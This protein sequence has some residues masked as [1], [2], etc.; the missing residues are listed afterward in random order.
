MSV[1]PIVDIEELT[2]RFLGPN[3]KPF[4]AVDRLSMKV[5]PG[6]L[7]ALVGPD[8]AGKTTLIRMMVGL[9]KPDSGRLAV[10]GCDVIRDPQTI[11]DR[12]S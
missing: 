8:G 4:P 3:G 7:T 5:Y 9:L 2:K 6:Q 10:L 1:A 12:I 11:Q